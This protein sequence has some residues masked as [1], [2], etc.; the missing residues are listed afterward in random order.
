[1]VLTGMGCLDML[2][3]YDA[4]KMSEDFNSKQTKEQLEAIE[5]D[6]K[7]ACLK[8]KL[9]TCHYGNVN[10]AVKNILQI[11]G[12]MLKEDYNQHDGYSLEIRW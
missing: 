2:N 12:Y 6:I 3:A 7:N 9:K 1:M 8:G 11:A 5:F 10:E 4:R